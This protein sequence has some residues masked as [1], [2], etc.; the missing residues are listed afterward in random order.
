MKRF[1][2]QIFARVFGFFW[3]PCVGCGLFFG[4]HEVARHLR[5]GVFCAAV[6]SEESTSGFLVCPACTP[7]VAITGASRAQVPYGLIY[8]GIYSG[9]VILGSRG[10]PISFPPMDPD[11]LNYWLKM[12]LVAAA[13]YPLFLLFVYLGY[14]NAWAHIG[15]CLGFALTMVCNRVAPP[16]TRYPSIVVLVQMVSAIALAANLWLA[17]GR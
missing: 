14:A 9:A 11:D 6:K 4:G 2:H 15:I 10:E 8:Y 3:M 13:I 5:R 16:L 1:L 17:V 7:Q 12:R